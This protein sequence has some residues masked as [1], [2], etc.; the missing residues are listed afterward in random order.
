[1]T[2][3]TQI[4]SIKFLWQN[5]WNKRK[6]EVKKNSDSYEMF[7]SNVY[8]QSKVLLKTLVLSFLVYFF[9]KSRLA[10]LAGTTREMF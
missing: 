8:S 9:L 3:G 10:V 6:G 4:L 1:M 7:L 2:S 5:K